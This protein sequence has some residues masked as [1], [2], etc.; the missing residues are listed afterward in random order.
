MLGH[1]EKRSAHY[2]ILQRTIQVGRVGTWEKFPLATCAT[3]TDCPNGCGSSSE[4][5]NCSG[6]GYI[7][8]DRAAL[9]AAFPGFSTGRA[10]KGCAPSWPYSQDS[11][12]KDPSSR[13]SYSPYHSPQCNP[14]EHAQ[15]GRGSRVKR[16]HDTPYME[17]TQSETPF[18]QNLQGQP[19]QTFR[20]KTVRRCW[21]LSQSSGQVPGAV[22][23]REESDSSSRPN[24]AGFTDE[25]GPLWDYD[26]RLQTQRHNDI[27]CG[28]QHARWYDY[29]RLSA[30][31]SAS[32]IYPLPQ[33]NR[34]RDPGRSQPALDRGQLRNSQAS[35][36]DSLAQTTFTVPF[37]FHPDFKFLV[38]H[39]RAVVSRD[40]RQTH[41]PWH[42]SECA[43]IDRG[44]QRT[45]STITTKIRRCLYGRHLW[46]RFCPK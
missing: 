14:L 24:A 5:N 18:D 42:V 37:A 27:I 45:I 2:I 7:E 22:C 21:A 31:P 25:E 15:H 38:E 26:S 10:G 1:H 41:P 40:H 12:G 35:Q 46:H 43:R 34:R 20:R 23:R 6:I 11:D 3:R 13:R 33:E 19:R 8:A 44:H 36:S 16:S 4:S 17:A 32:R 9:A 28:P 39:G 30:T 29:R